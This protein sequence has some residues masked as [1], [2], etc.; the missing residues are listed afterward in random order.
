MEQQFGK[1]DK[2]RQKP[3]PEAKITAQAMEWLAEQP[4]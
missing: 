2:E 4:G 1:P 3:G